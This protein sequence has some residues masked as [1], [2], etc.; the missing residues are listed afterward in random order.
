M[1]RSSGQ[2]GGDVFHGKEGVSGSSSEEGFLLGSGFGVFAF[3]DPFL[4]RVLS[5][6]SLRRPRRIDQLFRARPLVA[7]VIEDV[8]VRVGPA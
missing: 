6:Y 8:R 3:R 1:E 5:A 7:Q 4:V 2:V